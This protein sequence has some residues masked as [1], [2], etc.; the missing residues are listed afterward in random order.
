MFVFVPT[1]WD[2]RARGG[3]GVECAQRPH[4]HVQ[5]SSSCYGIYV[6]SQDQDQDSDSHSHFPCVTHNT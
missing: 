1:A 4:V 6:T 2:G 5:G 3:R